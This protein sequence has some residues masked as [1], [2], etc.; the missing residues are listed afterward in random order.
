MDMADDRAID[1]YKNSK[2]QLLVALREPLHGHIVKQQRWHH[3]RHSG[4]RSWGPGAYHVIK[5][6]ALSLS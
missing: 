5:E 6:G 1:K 4:P 3:P 2:S